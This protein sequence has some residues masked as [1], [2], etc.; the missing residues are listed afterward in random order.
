MEPMEIVK[1]EAAWETRNLGKLDTHYVNVGVGVLIEEGAVIRAKTLTIGD[2]VYIGKNVKI[3]V[4]GADVVIG[5]YTRINEGSFLGGT[6]Q[7][8][9]G[10]NCYI[11]REVQLDCRGGLKIGNNV[12]IGSLSQVWTH[13]RHGDT[14]QGC[15]WDKEYPLV[16]GDDAWLVARVTVGGAQEI[17]AR[18]MVFNESNVTKSLE[19]DRAYRGNPAKD[20][21][22]Q[23]GPQFEAISDSE[24]VQRLLWELVRFESEHP[25]LA[26][27][28]RVAEHGIHPDMQDGQD[29]VWFDPIR[30]KYTKKYT[31]AEVTFLRW[32][33]AKFTPWDGI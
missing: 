3:F 7:L 6:N 2:F 9:I 11:G 23:T 14:V 29:V 12:G 18:A 4:P 28:L 8:E 22:D 1:P 19:A 20:C 32:T 24:K 17:G 25:G 26:G 16:I 5:D 13:I 31:R 33:L 30:R 15:R 10:A 21:T 27:F